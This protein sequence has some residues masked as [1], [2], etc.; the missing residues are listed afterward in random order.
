MASNWI[1]TENGVERTVSIL[2]DDGVNAT[3]ELDGTTYTVRTTDL[4]DGRIAL[5]GV[6]TPRKLRT[7]SD[8]RGTWI[9]E[10]PT[11]RNFDIIDER[12]SWLGALGSG[13]GD[14]GGEIKASMPGRVVKVLVEVGDEVPAG[15]IVVVLE[16]MKMEN[17]I[18]TP[19]GGKVIE[20]GVV[21]GATVESGELLV[22]LEVEA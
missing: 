5:S 4:P 17:D 1:L 11:A 22:R 3:V 12:A 7:F 9:S 21:E 2:S 18:K 13:G 16:A 6:G 15:G 14:G 19:S 20:V 10:G 8:R